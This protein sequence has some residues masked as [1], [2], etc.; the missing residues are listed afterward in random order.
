MDQQ[1]LEAIMGLIIH[2]GNAKSDAMEAIRAAKRSNFAALLI[3]QSF[4]FLQ[5]LLTIH[6]PIISHINDCYRNTFISKLILILLLHETNLW[7]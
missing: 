5:D 1:N 2:S 6:H 3:H 7:S 4:G